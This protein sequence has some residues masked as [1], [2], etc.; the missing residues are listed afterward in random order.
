MKAVIADLAALLPAIAAA[1]GFSTL[2]LGPISTEDAC[3]A[4]AEA[5]FEKFSRKVDMGEIVGAS[6][7]MSAFDV[8]T[9]NY[10]AHIICAFGPDNQ[11]QVTLVVYYNDN[12]DDDIA[13]DHGERLKLVWKSLN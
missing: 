12:G 2:D 3:L 9:D 13:R 7:N 5:T 10:D 11:T 8:G 1:E 4:R 6:W